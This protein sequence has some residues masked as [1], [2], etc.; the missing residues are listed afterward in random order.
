MILN[1]V[2]RAS[3]AK[4]IEKAKQQGVAFV[5]CCSI[6]AEGDGILRNVGG[7]A[8]SAQICHTEVARPKA[9]YTTPKRS[10]PATSSGR[11]PM[12]SET[13]PRK[14]CAR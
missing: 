1:A 2:N 14:G 10:H 3:V 6:E 9:K 12:R 11:R 7:T 4:Q 8:N 13:T 5:T